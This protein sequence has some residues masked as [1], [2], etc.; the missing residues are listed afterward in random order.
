MASEVLSSPESLSE[1]DEAIL[2]VRKKGIL[3]KAAGIRTFLIQFGRPRERVK[4]QQ[5]LSYCGI[6]AYR[7][8]QRASRGDIPVRRR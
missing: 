6:G 1:N 3:N 7:A 5:A 4:G 2:P 8:F